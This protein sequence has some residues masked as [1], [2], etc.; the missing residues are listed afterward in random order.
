[1]RFINSLFYNIGIS[2]SKHPL[3]TISW[4]IV[5]CFVLSLGMINLKLEDDP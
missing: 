3:I 5:L 4:C 1:M 2:A